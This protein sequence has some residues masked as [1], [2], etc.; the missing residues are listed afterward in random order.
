MHRF[1]FVVMLLGLTLPLA[2]QQPSVADLVAQLKKS[3][4]EKLKA[5]EAIDAL[6][7]K[8]ADATSGLIELLSYKNEDVRLAATMALGKIGTPAVEPLN[9]VLEQQYTP[10]KNFK[11]IDN[12][13]KKLGST[14]FADRDSARKEIEAMG[15]HAIE[16]LKKAIKENTDLE[17]RRR[18]EDIVKTI[19]NTASMRFYTVWS[20]AFIG[21]PAKSATD[22]VV[23]AMGDP[24]MD[25]RRKAAY[26]LGRIDA[27]PNKVVNVLVTAL[28]DAD[29]DVRQMAAQSLPKMSKVAVPVLIHALSDKS[30]IKLMAIK[31]LGDCGADAAPAIF[32]L[33]DILIEGK[34]G[35]KNAAD[36]LA[37]IGPASIKALTVAA[38]HDGSAE[39][40]LA[41][42]QALHKIGAPSVPTFVDL[43]G[44]KHVD[45]QR[46]VAALLGGMLVQ[47]KSVVI[48]LGFATKDKD[49]QVRAN[50]L[51]SLQ[52][53]GTGAKLAEPYVV[54][55]LTDLDPQ[56]RL[57]AFNT[58]RTIGVDPQ[59]GLKKALSH[60][61]AKT[62]ITTASLM[63]QLNLEV[64]LATP[65]LLEGLKEKDEALKT[66]A[67]YALALRGL[68]G[69]IVLPIFLNALKNEMP[70]VRRQAAEMI[71]KYGSNASKATPD[72]IH[73]LDDKDDAVCAQAL[74]T[75]RVIGADAKL[76]FP[77]MVK[78]L[79]RPDTKLHPT[80]ASVI[81]QVGPNAIPQVIEMLKNDDAPGVRL[82]CLQTLAMVGPPAKDA[83]GELI[84]TL[85]DPTARVRMTA[86]RALGNIGPDA[87]AAEDALTKAAKDADGN[88]KTI[89]EAA[90]KQIKVDPN[91]KEF[92]VNGVLTPG[93][94]MDK[95]RP[96]CFHVVHTYP[97]TKGKS[98]TILLNSQW[99]NYLRLENPQ[100]VMLAQD[101]DGQGF[102]NAKIVFTAPEDG[103]YRIIV[104]TF[105]GNTSGPYTL[106]VK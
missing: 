18:C 95:V 89:A 98:Y 10:P 83:V 56:I 27:E 54:A 100:G 58:L 59:P 36:A 15:F 14:N 23:K 12:L 80:A 103:W 40:R 7:P 66:Q 105:S 81:F 37:A 77:A 42:V 106:R 48:G 1:V 84:K 51:Q 16:A 9:K 22:N 5:I 47:D 53:M 73:A 8:A 76:L 49:F 60:E 68:E 86:A 69:E 55:L 24:A 21:A 17:T 39:S 91:R 79:R 101:D 104:T 26:T 92:E 6:G 63:V 70:S 65:V 52:Q 90:L 96:G 72:L 11:Q 4:A 61:E 46:Q 35:S 93:D 3:D 28:G 38:Q 20:L 71:A 64:A 33:K 94:P 67:A 102:P 57:S 78:V 44:A 32:E 75:L 34:I 19:D 43:L 30:D 87:K 99:D 45:V 29:T 2:A 88:V 74:A 50:A 25:V 13:I 31:V 97:M 41:A 82:A 85:D 62:R